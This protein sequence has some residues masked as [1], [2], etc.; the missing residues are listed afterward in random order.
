M[1][2]T[3]AAFGGSTLAAVLSG[4][5]APLFTVASNFM[6][7]YILIAWYLVHTNSLVRAILRWR[8]VYALVSFGAM[9]AK[10]RAMFNFM[11][12]YVREYPQAVA[13]AIIL[14]G[15]SGSG[16]QLFMSVEKIVQK[17][18]STPSEFSSPGWG[19]KSAYIAALA[20]YIAIDPEDI[21]YDFGISVF[22]VDRVTARFYISAALCFHS[23]FETLYGAH[24]N[25]LFWFDYLF[26]KITGLHRDLKSSD[27]PQTR[28]EPSRRTDP[29]A[30][31]STKGPH[32]MS[33]G[34]RKRR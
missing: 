19:F 3:S 18:M 26:Y 24:I 9:A 12:D 31:S 33:D 6:M 21:L 34:L 16:G 20:Y 1:L 13:G 17:G 8:P 5:P 15:L 2:A 29:T 30:N 14:G 7:S 11:D 27:P 32:V 25:P 22:R 10:S 4:R 23:F 28:P